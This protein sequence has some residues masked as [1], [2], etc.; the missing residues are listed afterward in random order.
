V[1]SAFADPAPN[2]KAEIESFVKKIVIISQKTETLKK[3]EPLQALI[4]DPLSAWEG[5]CFWRKTNIR[6]PQLIGWPASST[7]YEDPRLSLTW[8]F[9]GLKDGPV[10]I[11]KS[12]KF[13]YLGSEGCDSDKPIKKKEWYGRWILYPGDYILDQKKV[14]EGK[15]YVTSKTQSSNTLLYFRSDGENFYFGINRTTQGWLITYV[16]ADSEC[17]D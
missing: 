8:K 4:E 16:A 17:S 12:K 9:S 15:D 13:N 11:L 5:S 14:C 1:I 7:A 2:Q 3:L 6:K 10:V